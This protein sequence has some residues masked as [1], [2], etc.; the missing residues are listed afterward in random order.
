MRDA[1]DDSFDSLSPYAYEAHRWQRLEREPPLV[2]G[3]T[4]LV[5]AAC[6]L[7]LG[8]VAADVG[9]YSS[10]PVTVN[11]TAVEW[12]IPGTPLAT[13]A[14]FSL[15]GS[16]SVTVTLTCSS[17][18]IRFSGATVESPFTLLGFSVVYHPDQYTNVT[19]RAPATAYTGPIAIQL[20]VA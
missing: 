8:F 18:C 10:Q 12:F 5:V 3:T 19:V 15:H 13:T 14:G 17:V 2:R 11:V 4:L 7:L 6:L 20:N 16:S 9:L 1:W